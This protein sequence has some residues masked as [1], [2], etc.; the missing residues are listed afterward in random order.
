MQSL[1]TLRILLEFLVD[2]AK[3]R[4]DRGM[5]AHPIARCLGLAAVGAYQRARAR[6]RCLEREGGASH[7]DTGSAARTSTRQSDDA[8]I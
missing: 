8:P 5:G 3:G 6:N 4:R 1:A 7:C 2:F